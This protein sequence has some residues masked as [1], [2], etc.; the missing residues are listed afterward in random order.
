MNEMRLSRD[1]IWLA[2]DMR[3]EFYIPDDMPVSLD[4]L[5]KEKKIF[6]KEVPLPAGYLGAS[7]TVGLKKEVL[8]SNQIKDS[9]RKK[10]T[11]AHELGHVFLHQGSYRCK[12]SFMSLAFN[13]IPQET[14][15][16]IFASELLMPGAILRE[17]AENKDI[18]VELAKNISGTY[19]TS[20]QSALMGLIKASPDIVCACCYTRE[21]VLW[22]IKSMGC[23]YELRTKARWPTAV[24]MGINKAVPESWFIDDEFPDDTYCLEENYIYP[25]GIYCLSI[26]SLQ[27]EEF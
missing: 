7:R 16:N 15:A 2:R 1:P 22:N 9:G 18:T 27:S 26:I 10:F 8:V 11:I 4:I 5:I 19:E 14:E 23:T 21:K 17:T 20:L 25:G 12:S 24:G 13:K 6:Y 3:Q